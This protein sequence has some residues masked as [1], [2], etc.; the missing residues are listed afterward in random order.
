MS[1]IWG[2]CA[3]MLG[4]AAVAVLAAGTAGAQEETTLQDIVVTATKR[5]TDVQKTPIAM[6]V[7]TGDAL[8]NQGVN[9]VDALNNA[10]PDVNFAGGGL[11]TTVITIRGISSQ[12]VTEL[13]DPAVSLNFDG[14]YLTRPLGLNGVLFDIS[15]VEV[16]RGP[17]GTLYGRNATAGAV[18][19]ITNRPSDKYE[20]SAS[21]DVGNYGSIITQGMVNVP[22][23]DTLALRASF[24]TDDRDGYRDHGEN[25]KSDD[26]QMR[27]ARLRALYTPTD[28]FSALITGEYMRA[29]GV[30]NQPSG[31]LL[32][33][34]PAT[35]G[36]V[37]S[38][39]QPDLGNTANWPLDM[40]GFFHLD[41]SDL[42]WELNYDFDW[43][44]LTYVGGYRRVTSHQLNDISGTA[45]Q[46]VDY[47]SRSDYTTQGHEFR[48][49]S[50][51]GSPFNWQTGVYYSNEDQLT[52]SGLFTPATVFNGTRD[53]YT[54]KFNYPNVNSTSTALFAQV[55]EPLT[56][57]LT[58][59]QGVR[60]THDEK[61]R[62]G[63]QNTLNFGQYF[64]TGGHII[65][66]TPLDVGGQG[67]W[68][69]TNWHVGLDWQVTPDS[70]VYVK[71]SSG[72]K[73]GGFTTVNTYGPEDLRAYEIGTKN[74]FWNNR[75]EVNGD[76]FHYDY[77]GQQVATFVPTN[78][79][80]GL[81]VLSTQNAG[82]STMD[83]VEGEVTVKATSDD[84]LHFSANYL[85]AEFTKFT[86]AQAV[87]VSSTSDPGSV[88]VNLKGN[89]P[90]QSPKWTLGLS[91]EHTFSFSWGDIVTTAQGRYLSSYY[92]TPYNLPADRQAGYHQTDL[93]VAY[94]APNGHW[95][96]MAYV[97]N[98]EDN[99]VITYSSFTS[100][101]GSN[102]YS[103]TFAPPLTY[104]A[105]LAVHW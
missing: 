35:L 104:G 10:A 38:T 97:R 80:S 1:R 72:Y 81:S 66:Y 85:F 62:I 16:L 50:V 39:Y 74:R 78:D 95:D 64:G 7:V 37:P 12:D 60:W 59:T 20:A 75:L 22:V 45:T 44:R 57:S 24:M 82:A 42:R 5:A 99:R 96:L 101:G 86:G 9:S 52:D 68:Y 92:L 58:F 87:I 6:D 94:Y 4:A 79:G 19:I 90:P 2:T 70:M 41:Q 55:S 23:S 32:P 54:V 83:G 40:K 43:A 30:G 17:Q 25:G 65:A 34:T 51:A 84:K 21:L 91:W 105:R 77:T 102:V 46:V 11:N 73:S 36:K 53:V 31:F 15:R 3:L 29:G 61:S 69:R 93:N 27:A 14:E 49:S 8:A 100:Q 33:S 26:A 71:A 76:L 47:D 28:R 18:N 88:A 89:T 63:T 48:L 13:G 103:F 98:L 56:D 67:S